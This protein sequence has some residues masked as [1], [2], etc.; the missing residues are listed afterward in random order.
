MSPMVV[1]KT[2]TITQTITSPTP[3]TFTNPSLL[4]GLPTKNIT[5]T[6]G[7]VNKP[8]SIINSYNKTTNLTG[9]TN[10]SS[11]YVKGN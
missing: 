9:A 11:G 4:A 3:V 6:Q 8:P 7:E 1:N 5:F 2:P 10:F